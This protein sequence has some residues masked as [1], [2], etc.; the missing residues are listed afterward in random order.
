RHIWN[1]VDEFA[2]TPVSWRASNRGT[3]GMSNR[4]AGHRAIAARRRSVMEALS[5]RLMLSVTLVKDELHV[6]GTGSADR[7]SVGATPFINALVVDDNNVLHY[8]ALSAIKTMIINAK[9]GDDRVTVDP[10]LNALGYQCVIYGGSGNDTL[11]GSGG[12]VHINGEEGNDRI[13]VYATVSGELIGENGRDC[14][15]GSHTSDTIVGGGG[16]DKIYGFGGK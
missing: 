13:R 14:L 9:A 11:T 8:Y 3:R 4:K 1:F 16:N 7:I 5:P 10:A 12:K 15:Y 2:R 6:D